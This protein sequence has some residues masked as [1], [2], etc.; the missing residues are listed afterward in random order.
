MSHRN[1]WRGVAVVAA[2]ALVLGA[3]SSSKKKVATTGTTGAANAGGLKIGFFGALTGPNSPQLGINERNGVQLAL[4]QHNR[5]PGVTKVS[6]V[7]YDSQ[8][9]PAQAPQLAQKAVSDKVL[10]IVGPAFSGESKVADPIFEQAGIPNVTASATNATLQTHGFRFFHRG[11]AN[12]DAQAPADAKFLAKK[13][14]AK[15]V[16]VID[17]ASDYGKGLADGVRKAL[18]GLGAT[19][20]VGAT[21]ESI[22]P[23]AQDFSSTVNKINAA[24][25]D[26]IFYGGYYA[27]SGRLLKQLHDAGEKA[28]FESGDGSEDQKLVDVGGAATEG[29]Y[30]TCACSDVTTDPKAT[31]F[32]TAFK[33]EFN[34]PPAIYSA[35][36][37]D[38]TNFILA[39]VDSGATTASAINNYLSTSSYTGLT[40]T[41]KFDSKG[42]ITG[43]SIYEYQVKS[44]KI[45]ELGVVDQLVSG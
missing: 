8:G 3:C 34:S 1:W 19:I 12:D 22:D 18:P 40:K 15:K 20:V 14:G 41:L 13:L 28:P 36:A 27:D 45:T 39:A 42:E 7:P 4:D 17:D 24:K 9:D 38:V 32:V 37:Y 6:L 30:L 31:D 2:A 25:P 16:A 10:A 5:K 35:E 23:K 33:A 26:A 11:L 29:A 21:G 44:L 43:G